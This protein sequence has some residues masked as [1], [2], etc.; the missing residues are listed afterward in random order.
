MNAIVYDRYGLPE[1][2]R[3]G[4][5]EKPVPGDD[6]IL[7]RVCAVSVNRSDWEG[8]IGKPL[9]SRMSGLRKPRKPILG[10]D[11]AGRVEAVGQNQ[12]QFKPGDEVFG[13]M[14]DYHGG[15]AEYICTRPDAWTLKPAELTFEQASAIPQAGVI[16]L[17]GLN[18]NGELRPGQRVLINGAGGGAGS[19][20]IQLAKSYGA[21]VTGVDNAGKLEFMRSLGADQ[22]IDYAKEDF[23]KSGESYDLIL[24]LIA[25]RSAFACARALR[26]GGS[27]FAVGGPVRVLLQILFLRRLIRLTTGRNV[28]ILAVHRN[29]TDLDR[30]ADLCVTGRI[31]PYIDIHYSLDQVPEALQYLGDGLAKGKIVISL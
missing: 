6:E 21:E 27:Y 15:F 9:Y 3:L 12:T 17:Q 24:D 14:E 20:A 11:V 29:R 28:N 16:A 5:V 4:E 18:R 7:V 25:Q 30:I 2:L 10:S 23:T 26:K 8:L 13:E 22:V 1:V 19:F 31:V